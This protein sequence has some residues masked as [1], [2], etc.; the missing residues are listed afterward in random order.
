[1]TDFEEYLN[2]YCQKH[3]IS[4][5]EALE[6]FIVKEIAKVYGEELKNDKRRPVTDLLHK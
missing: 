2:K 6:H 5:E 3:N 4:R 1:M